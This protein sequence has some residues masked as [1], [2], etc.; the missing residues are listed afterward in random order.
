MCGTCA[1][2][3]Q[4]KLRALI[5][6]FT[7]IGSVSMVNSFLTPNYGVENKARA[8]N[9]TEFLNKTAS[10]LLRNDTAIIVIDNASSLSNENKSQDSKPSLS[11]N[12]NDITSF[13]RIS[14]KCHVGNDLIICPHP[15]I[16][17]PKNPCNIDPTAISCPPPKFGTA[18]P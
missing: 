7:L 13:K 2:Y 16:G 1:E 17:G 6:I 10:L 18:S 14:T 8:Q 3:I 12:T 4:H 15:S 5:L 9:N 11:L